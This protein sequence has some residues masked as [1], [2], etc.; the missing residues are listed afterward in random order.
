MVKKMPVAP[1]A[2]RTSV[3]TSV[4]AE[5]ISYLAYTLFQARGHEHGHDVEDWLLAEAE[6]LKRHNTEI[7][8]LL[9]EPQRRLE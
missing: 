3:V 9:A 1:R 5:A 2:A 4:P 8:S 7:G 6:L